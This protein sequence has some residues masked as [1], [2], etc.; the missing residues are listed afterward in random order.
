MLREEHHDPLA[1]GI[2]AFRFRL[3]TRG[4]RRPKRLAH[5][6]RAAFPRRLPIP[7]RRP[8]MDGR[9]GRFTGLTARLRREL[10]R[11]YRCV[12]RAA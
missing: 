9:A 3:G 6:Y 12:T 7:G 10:A 2:V 1:Q 11:P 4:R 8:G 5:R